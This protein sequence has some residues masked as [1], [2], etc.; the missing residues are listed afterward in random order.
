MATKASRKNPPQVEYKVILWTIVSTADPSIRQ[1]KIEE[2]Y[3][4][5]TKQRHQDH[6]F[7][8]LEEVDRKVQRA[9]WFKKGWFIESRQ[10]LS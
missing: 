5:V 6:R 7:H 1:K 9:G 2:L 4:S 8:E 10:R 3:V